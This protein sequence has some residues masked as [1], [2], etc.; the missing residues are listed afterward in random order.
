MIREKK[1]LSEK[2]SFN[3]WL[4]KCIS[5][6]VEEF[7]QI[8]GIRKG[9]RKVAIFDDVDIS[10][11][12]EREIQ[13]QKVPLPYVIRKT[14]E[15]SISDIFTEIR[16]GQNQTVND[17]GDYVLGDKKND[18]MMRFYYAM[19]GFVRR[20]VWNRIIRSPFQTKKNMGTVLV[21]SVGMMG[22]INGWVIPVSVHPLCFAIGSIIKKPGV[23]GDK[24]EIREYL[25]VTA[26]VDHDV[27]DG[28]PAIR[29][30]SKL[31]ELVESGYGL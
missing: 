2:V 18:F 29:A 9:K 10:I 17:E 21:T 6:A 24:I 11:M 25:Y 4:I 16:D 19:P 22:K 15:K 8:H 5:H 3:S 26:L 7:P 20:M 13:G 28:A 14:N 1:K 23:I 12:I 30:L 31:T 27:V